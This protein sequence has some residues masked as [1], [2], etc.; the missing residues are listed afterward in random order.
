MYKLTRIYLEDVESFKL[1]ISRGVP[2]HHHHQLQVLGIADVASHC[3]EIVPIKQQLSKK[4]RG[5]GR[6]REGGG[7][8]ER[9]RI[10]FLSFRAAT[11]VRTYL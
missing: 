9:E 5:G 4:L 1:Y 7:G 3:R 8:R 2:E 10:I 6:G 11:D